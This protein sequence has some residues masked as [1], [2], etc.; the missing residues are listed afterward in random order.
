MRRAKVYCALKLYDDAINDLSKALIIDPSNAPIILANR[1]EIYRL[2]NRFD[3][4]LEDLNRALEREENSMALERRGA[5]LRTLGKDNDALADFM[6][7][8]QLDP[9]SFFAHKN[10]AEILLSLGYKDEALVNLNVA[11]QIDRE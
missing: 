1:G 5:V 10:C 9:R 11:L 4:A 6:R 8:I 3:D 2:I 7:I